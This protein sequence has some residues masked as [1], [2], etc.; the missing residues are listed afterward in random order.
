MGVRSGPVILSNRLT[1]VINPD[2]CLPQRLISNSRLDAGFP[3]DQNK[4]FIQAGNTP[5][6]TCLLS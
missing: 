5:N 6:L 4:T 1:V 3:V 2:Q